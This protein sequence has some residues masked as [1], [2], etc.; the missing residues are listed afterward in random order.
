MNHNIKFCHIPTFSKA[1]GSAFSEDPGM[2]PGL[3]PLCKICLKKS[4]ITTMDK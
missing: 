1:P 3:A 2:R 4:D